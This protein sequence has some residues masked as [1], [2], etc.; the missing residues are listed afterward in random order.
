MRRDRLI[1]R[2]RLPALGDGRRAIRDHAAEG[3]G[4]DQ[5][6]EKQRKQVEAGKNG[7]AAGGR[8]PKRLPVHLPPPCFFCSSL[9]CSEKP[10]RFSRGSGV[11]GAVR[12]ASAKSADLLNIAGR[13]TAELAKPTMSSARSLGF[14]SERRKSVT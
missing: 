8:M 7:A 2:E 9:A 5:I 10:S 13:P 14:V 3:L 4:K 6:Q 11:I 1:A 12:P